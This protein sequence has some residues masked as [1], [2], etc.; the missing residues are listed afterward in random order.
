MTRYDLSG[1]TAIGVTNSFDFSSRISRILPANWLKADHA[2]RLLEYSIIF[3][4]HPNTNFHWTFRPNNNTFTWSG[5]NGV[6]GFT[7]QRR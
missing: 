1:L 3:S 6:I 7:E 4:W 2:A 5:P